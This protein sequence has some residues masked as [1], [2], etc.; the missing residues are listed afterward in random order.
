MQPIQVPGGITFIRD[1]FKAPAWT[2]RPLLDQLR[3]AHAR[4]KIFVLGTISDCHHKEVETKRLANEALEAADI[5][6]FTGRHAPAALKAH[7]E[8]TESRLYAFIRTAQVSDFLQSIQQDGDLIIV[9]GNE[10]KDHLSRLALSQTQTVN[11]WVDDCGR[12]M[13]CSECSH[14]HSRRGTPGFAHPAAGGSK[15]SVPL[16][17]PLPIV[18]A[19]NHIVIGLGNPGREYI[20]TPHNVGYE[21][22]NLLCSSNSSTWEEHPTAWIAE[23]LIDSH[24]LWLIKVKTPMNLTGQTLKRLSETMK[25]SVAQCIL[26]FDDIDLPIGKVRTR[27]SGSSGGHRGVASILEAFQSDRFRRIKIGVKRSSSSTSGVLDQFEETEIVKICSS[28]S[29]VTKHLSMLIARS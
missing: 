28:F 27:M 3:E 1:D 24:K 25:F 6:I 17:E 14:L 13:F 16:A 22:L 29:E 8:G 21:T 15:S 23:G 11:C 19:T 18:A 12:D 2:V 20:G 26:V 4:R 10:K 7:R 9:K 5:A